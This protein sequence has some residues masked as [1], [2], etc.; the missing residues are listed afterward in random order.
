MNATAPYRGF[1]DAE[2]DVLLVA[3]IIEELMKL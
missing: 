1:S 2:I 3:D